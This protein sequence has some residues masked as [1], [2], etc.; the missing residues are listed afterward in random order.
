MEGRSY[1]IA[2]GDYILYYRKADIFVI[3]A[4]S[5]DLSHS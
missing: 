5:I 2:M 4:D 3:S 1:L